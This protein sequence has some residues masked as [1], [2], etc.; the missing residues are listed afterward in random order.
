MENITYE[1]TGKL[2][3]F[4][5]ESEEMSTKSRNAGAYSVQKRFICAV[6]ACAVVLSTFFSGNISVLAQDVQEGQTNQQDPVSTDTDADKSGIYQED[7]G[8]IRALQDF[9]CRL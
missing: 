6:L 3:Y 7:N 4:M 2:S 8:L 5:K 1:N 9:S